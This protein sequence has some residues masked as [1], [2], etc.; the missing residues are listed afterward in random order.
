MKK[1]FSLFILIAY[2][3][4]SLWGGTF[5]NMSIR[6]GLSSRQVFQIE[7]D[8]Q[9]FIWAYT[10][11]GID[12]YDGNKIK[13]YRLDHSIESRNHLHTSSIM[14]CSPS[15]NVWIGLRNGEVYA[16][17]QRTDSYIPQHDL[18]ETHPSCTL[19]NLLFDS[20]EQLW[21][22]MG[23]GL[24]TMHD[25]T[26]TLIGLEGKNV[27][28]MVQQDETTFFVGTD[29][30]VYRLH[31]TPDGFVEKQ[32]DIPEV[33]AEVLMIAN[34]KLYIGTFQNSVLSYNLKTG[35]SHSLDTFIPNAP[36]RAFAL[37]SPHSL[38]VASDGGGL[39]EIDTRNEKVAVHDLTTQNNQKDI[40]TISDICIDSEGCI[41]LSTSTNGI[42]YLS[43]HL[44]TIQRISHIPYN[45]N[46]LNS[47][48]VNT[49]FQDSKGNLWFG[50]NNGVSYYQVNTNQWSHYLC[51][52]A[53]D[54]RVVLAF[55]EDNQGCIYIGGYGFGVYCIQPNTG[56]I[57]K[58]PKRTKGTNGIASDYIYTIHRDGENLWFGGIEGEL[59]CFSPQTDKYTY[60]T[61]ECIGDM[62]SIPDET[63]LIAGC[64]GLGYL[65]KAANKIQWIRQLGTFTLN[66]PIRSILWTN[67]TIWMAT[68]GDG[69]VCYQPENDSIQ[70][71]TQQNGLSSNS[72]NSL[73]ED[74]LGRIWFTTEESLYCLNP[75]DQS[76]VNANDY[77]GIDWGYYNPNAAYKS[78]DGN[79]LFGTAEGVICIQPVLDFAIQDSI[80]LILTNFKLNYESI[81]A[82][83]PESILKNNINQT[84]SIQLKH[85]QNNF[86]IS[87][88]T[89]NYQTPKRIRYEY[90]LVDYTD[91]NTLNDI[92][93]IHYTNV[94]SGKYTFQLQAFD[95][96]SGKSMGIRQLEIEICQPF[97]LS[98]WAWC[99]YLLIGTIFI[100]LIYQYWKQR[101]TENRIQEKINTFINIAHDIR[102]PV[103]LI[104]APLSEL[105]S[106]ESLPENSRRSIAVANRN[107]EKLMN[108]VTQLLDLQKTE[109]TSAS[110][111]VTTCDISSYLNKK[112]TEFEPHA[113]QKG[114]SIILEL[115]PKLTTVHIDQRKMDHIIDNLLSNAL[116]YTQEGYIRIT[117]IDCGKKWELHCTDTG[118]GIPQ[119]EQRHI[120][121]EFF[122]A[123]NAQLSETPGSGIG[124]MITRKLVHQH[125]GQI[126]FH[127]TEGDGTTFTLRFPK[128]IKQNGNTLFSKRPVSMEKSPTTPEATDKRYILLLAEDD[129]DTLEFL[130]ECL[131]AEYRV[132]RVS[133]GKE[134]LE[135]AQTINPD[136]I[137]SDVV[138]PGLSGDE[139]CRKLK[140]DVATSHIPIILLTALCEREN[141]IWGLEAG[142]NDY[143]T[144]PFDLS[145]LKA[146]IRNIL[147]SRQH[148]RNAMLEM[149]EHPEETDYTSQL[150]KEFMEKVMETIHKELDNTELSINDFCQMLNMS[151]TSVY[152]KIKALTGQG[153]N[154][155]IRIVRLN[156]SKE[157]LLTRRY[158]I[159]EV[160]TLVGYS[161]PKYFSTSFKKQ[162]GISPSKI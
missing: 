104:K 82:G 70:T 152:N 103:T 121:R 120:F 136:I 65:P 114:I 134:A 99:I 146:R 30:H 74:H 139:L 45:E 44:P 87:F 112:K 113:H 109:F 20:N 75:Q 101:E 48:H 60:Y 106:E 117:T 16:Y 32:L 111:E 8:A 36:V 133:D 34:D 73:L 40:N 26:P 47:N 81:K 92:Q 29:H 39:F 131:S 13:H 22:C 93:D 102:T 161:D 77:L 46:S 124:L 149:K 42:N 66:Y 31:K 1:F 14:I 160:A 25:S 96:Y 2:Y 155:F 51:E 56:N 135:A 5:K 7:K 140:S 64:E 80:R 54:S 6:E 41:W 150:D 108:M 130:T 28:C 88:S 55:A 53:Y 24:Y 159:A 137:I 157:L 50:T 90:R 141:I 43:P 142:A 84:S 38:F 12:R 158:T 122:R 86:S 58:L 115:S 78:A 95:K 110:L 154:D 9:G 27:Y 162:F 132:I 11:V 19:N 33:R 116:K 17:D 127:S 35:E 153:P 148:L 118:I 94:P 10:S 63:L 126:T 76:L 85:H 105:Q 79:L 52:Q 119:K 147:L 125:L 69:L 3:C 23:N 4:T 18:K 21:L 143:I 61:N 129:N 68:D 123:K 72:I 49:I 89:I 67:Q 57:H 145:V 138:M 156:K 71:Y 107:V 128:Q 15:G 37:K 98:G 97:W 91:W 83:D 62:N 144:K 100:Y 151:R 59:T